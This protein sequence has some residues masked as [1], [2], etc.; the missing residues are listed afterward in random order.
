LELK[1]LAKVL[2][3]KVMRRVVGQQDLVAAQSVLDEGGAVEQI[4]ETPENQSSNKQPSTH[5][6]RRRKPQWTP[7]DYPVEACEGKT[8]F[9]AE[10]SR[11]SG[12]NR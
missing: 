3:N 6:K 12:D 1:S 9:Y 7:K 8:R 5:K 11:K 10:R 4:A 2:V